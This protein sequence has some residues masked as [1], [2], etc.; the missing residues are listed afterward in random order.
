MKKL[1]VLLVPLLGGCAMPDWGWSAWGVSDVSVEGDDRFIGEAAQAIDAWNRALYPHCGV[2]VFTFV[3]SGG[4]R[5]LQLDAEAWQEA[6]L[7][8][9]VIGL[10]GRDEIIILDHPEQRATLVHELGHALGLDHTT[11]KSDPDTCM[12][13]YIVAGRYEPSVKD[14][15]HAAQALGCL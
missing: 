11:F 7:P 13:P 5:I 4:R 14:V 8:A 3:E 9:D 2:P 12:Y 6:G 15:E 1:S 10:Q